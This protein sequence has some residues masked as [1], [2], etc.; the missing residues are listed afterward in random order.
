LKEFD[1]EKRSAALRV[2]RC[3]ARRNKFGDCSQ[4]V[5]AGND[6][7]LRLEKLAALRK[8]SYLK[9]SNK[10]AFSENYCG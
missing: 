5:L 2:A 7:A 4:A 1:E 3:G 6:V 9:Q 10:K 8:L